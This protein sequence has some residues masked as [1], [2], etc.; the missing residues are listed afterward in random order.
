MAHVNVKIDVIIY[1]VSLKLKYTSKSL[2]SDNV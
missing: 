2:R 1:P